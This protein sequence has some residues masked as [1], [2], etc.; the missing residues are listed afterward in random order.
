M[1]YNDSFVCCNHMNWLVIW[2]FLLIFVTTVNKLIFSTF[3]CP[4]HVSLT[5]V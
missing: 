2:F 5:L 4:Y 1:K 3:K